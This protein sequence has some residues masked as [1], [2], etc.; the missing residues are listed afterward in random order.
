MAKDILINLDRIDETV[1][2]K[3]KILSHVIFY[4]EYLGKF[5]NPCLYI[6]DNSLHN[7]IF[8]RT[9]KY[10]VVGIGFRLENEGGG[11]VKVP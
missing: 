6:R 1:S 11:G 7:L 8:T 4:K 3:S 2:V 5:L 10:F 9:I